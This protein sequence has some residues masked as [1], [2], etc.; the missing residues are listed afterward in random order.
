M[1]CTYHIQI[2]IGLGSFSITFYFGEIG[3]QGQYLAMK[4]IGQANG[5]FC[6]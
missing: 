4:S 3:A 1:M 2:Q 6:S 5:L